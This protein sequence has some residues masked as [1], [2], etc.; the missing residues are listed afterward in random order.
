M[1][2]WEDIPPDFS[3]R[4][5]LPNRKDYGVDL[6]DLDCTRTSQV[7]HYGAK[8]SITFAH[9]STFYTF[10]HATLGITDM[11]LATTSGARIV[12]H[13]IDIIKKKNMGLI[14]EDFDDLMKRML[15]KYKDRKI[16]IE[17][18]DNYQ[19]I[20]VRDY[21]SECHIIT[22]VSDK[23]VLNFQLPCGTGKSYIMMYIIK[24]DIATPGNEDNKFIIF[25]PWKDLAIQTYDLFKK[26]HIKTCLIGNGNHVI[27]NQ[28]NVIICI[29][30]SVD[31][32]LKK[33]QE[34]KYRFIDEAHHLENENSAIKNKISKIKAEKEINL[35]ATFHDQSS[36][37]FKYSIND[38]ITDGW[39]SDYLLHIEYFTKGD[40]TSAMIDM[41]C[42]NM[43]WAPMFIYFNSTERAVG[44]CNKLKK[45]G[46]KAEYLIGT[47]SEKKRA[48]VKRGV[49]GGDV[50]VVCLCGVY[51]EGVSIDNLRTVI[52][53]DLRHSWINKVQ[54]AM[55]ASRMHQDKPFYRVVMPVTECDFGESDIRDLIKTFA[56]IDPRLRADIKKKSGSRIMIRFPDKDNSN[57][58][59]EID[60]AEMLYETVYGRLGNMVRDSWDD[61]LKDV[62]EWLDVNKRRPDSK[63]TD[64]KE[65]KYI[66]WILRHHSYYEKEI[67]SM[68]DQSNKVKWENFKDAYKKYMLSNDD[69]WNLMIKECSLW[70]DKNKR[71]PIMTSKNLHER[72]YGVW[73]STQRK[74]LKKT[75]KAM[76]VPDKRKRWKTFLKRYENYIM[77]DNAKWND[78][79]RQVATFIDNNGTRPNSKIE[80]ERT[81]ASWLY[82]QQCK[83]KNDDLASDVIE[84][85]EIFASK[86][87]Q[88]IIQWDDLWYKTLDEVQQ[89]IDNNDRKPKYNVD[90]EKILC[91]WISMQHQYYKD[92]TKCMKDSDKRAKWGKFMKK[93]EHLKT[94][95][96]KWHDNF[97]K[98]E[99]FIRKYNRKPSG[100]SKVTYEQ[101]LGSWMSDQRRFYNR[102]QTPDWGIVRKQK[103]DKLIDDYPKLF[104]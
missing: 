54:I 88:Y 14:R 18:V 19:C 68:S 66:A 44:F 83:Y 93:N 72:K 20:N 100:Y 71:R 46:V 25:C 82:K 29:N 42:D 85:W 33:N 89:F 49:I 64:Q 41:V 70:I 51:N 27:D 65:R 78:M 103:I 13:V 48:R 59:G 84:K 22:L 47:D 69:K 75:A 38:A 24:Y 104:T 96:D 16:E 11:I 95:N 3:D 101:K 102:P 8:S 55:R 56:E 98:V 91:R 50:K 12:P 45:R 23:K 39:I 2:V 21:Q 31:H 61:V 76:S 4:F 43:E 80:N 35:S 77:T 32:V 86:Y 6:I 73:L 1:V 34:F 30:P 9:L 87:K 37:D 92:G 94:Q 52:F 60:D 40:K 67:Y 62:S 53:G 97:D 17:P 58:G 28:A 57:D 74:N 15:I 63:S 36:L 90:G 10:S 5:D 81:I 26:Y 99:L 7:K 79:L